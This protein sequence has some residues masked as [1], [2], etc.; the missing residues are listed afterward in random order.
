MEE[1]EEMAHCIARVADGAS[2][3]QWTNE[4]PDHMVE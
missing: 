4:V 1:A 3:G 2:N